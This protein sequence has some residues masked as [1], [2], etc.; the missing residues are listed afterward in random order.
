MPA[1]FVTGLALVLAVCVWVAF[2]RIAALNTRLAALEAGLEAGLGQ[3]E[4][5]AERLSAV[6]PVVP[7]PADAGPET[8][9]PQPRRAWAAPAGNAALRNLGV[10]LKDNWIYPVAGAALVMA[11]VYLVQYSVEKGLISP[12]ARIGLALGLGVALIAG[13]EVLRRRWGDKAQLVPATLSGAGVATLFAAVLAAH[14]LYALIGQE[15]TLIVLATVAFAAMLLGWIQGPLLA[16]IGIIAGGAAPFLLGGGGPPPALLYAYFGTLAASGLGIDGL[17]RWGWISALAV[18]VPVAG[19]ILI[20]MAGAPGWGLAALALTVTAMAL[21]L[22]GGALVPHA[23]GPMI[24]QARR[25]RPAIE[26]WVAALAVFLATVAILWQV[27]APAGV[28]AAGLLTLGVP[29]WTRRAPALSDL[30]LIAAAA[31]PLS[32]AYSVTGTPLMLSLVL[33]LAGWLPPAA[34]ALGAAAGL[35][36]LWR[37]E[38]ATGRARELWAILGIATPGATAIAVELFWKPLTLLGFQWPLAVMALGAGFTAVALAAARRDQGQ[39]ARL[40]AAAAGAVT[41]IALALMLILSEA[42]L[43]LALAVL[44]VATAAMDRR[45]HIPALGWVLGLGAMTLGWRLLV[46]PGIDA[47]IDLELSGLDVALTL[48]AVLAGPLVALA[49]IRDLPPHPSRDWGRIITET[50]LSGMVPFALIIVFARFLEQ[51]TAHAA[52]GIEASALIALAGVQAARARR[53]TGSRAMTMVRRVLAGLLGLA[54]ALCL[55][56]GATMLSPVF[57]SGFLAGNVLGWP[58]LNDLLL[59]YAAPA[60]VLALALRGASGRRAGAGR[61]VAVLLGALWA[62][63][64]IRHLWQGGENMALWRG[65]A[66]GELYAY[67]VAL[68]LAGA[69]AMG[70]ALHSGQRFYRMAGLALIGLAAAKAFLIDASGLT[71]LMR[72]GAFLGLGLSLAALAWLNAWIAGHAGSG[73]QGPRNPGIQ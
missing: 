32:I 54:A 38:E 42:A 13:G 44:M 28:V 52:L 61:A 59:A 11:A 23:T 12:A 68:L 30:S 62:G 70:L 39:G 53:L 67:T 36:M 58:L 9:A 34:V 45:F 5:P 3:G 20:A 40:G 21:A 49:L 16:A 31:L 43:T 4:A 33:N 17:R 29:L 55:L 35:A 24:H 2:R 37:S 57:G 27:S 66:Q 48:L 6:I 63:H 64:A 19:G 46:D 72:V 56:A 50:A 15:Q 10:W 18:V 14:H 8:E 65:F 1:D 7:A 41:M 25:T 47:A 71:G 73:P 22:P 26:V 51:I 69:G 60:L